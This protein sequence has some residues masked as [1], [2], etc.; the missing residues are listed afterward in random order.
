MTGSAL[1]K[2]ATDSTRANKLG[3]PGARRESVEVKVLAAGNLVIASGWE[4]M[5]SV[6]TRSW[7]ETRRALLVRSKC[8]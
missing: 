4:A 7:P 3:R 1:G 6:F 2:S 5:L 8:G